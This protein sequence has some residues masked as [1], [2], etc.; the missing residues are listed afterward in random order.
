MKRRSRLYFSSIIMSLAILLTCYRTAGAQVSIVVGSG[1]YPTCLGQ[2]YSDILWPSHFVSNG[3]YDPNGPTAFAN[4]NE[5]VLGL[6][7][8][9]EVNPYGYEAVYDSSGYGAGGSEVMA[10]VAATAINRSNTNN[11][12]ATNLGGDNPWIILAT[13]DMSPTIW[14]VNSKGTGGLKSGMNSTLLNTLAGAP[15]TQACDGLMYSWAMGIAAMAA[16]ANGT[17]STQLTA[18]P[19]NIFPKTLFFNSDGSVPSTSSSRKQFLQEVGIAN[20]PKYPSS[21]FPWYFWTITDATSYP[22]NS[23]PWLY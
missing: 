8:F 6:T 7:I 1:P 22:G 19:T 23:V 2:M 3:Y 11:I 4:S 18:N 5:G 16:H 14:S 21:A 10:S 17:M 13:K 9:F 20:A 12:D 15:H